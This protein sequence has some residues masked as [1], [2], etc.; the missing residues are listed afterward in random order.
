MVC[1]AVD[2][3]QFNIA[4]GHKYRYCD[5]MTGKYAPTRTTFMFLMM[6]VAMSFWGGSWVSAKLISLSMAPEMTAFWRFFLQA[7]V[8]LAVMII[9]RKQ[10]SIGKEKLLLLIGTSLILSCYN[11][12]F[13]FGLQSGFAGK[14]GVIVTCLNPL[15]AFG[16]S[17]IAF[18][19]RIHTMQI[20][21]LSVGLLGGMLLLETSRII[22]SG[23]IDS[24]GFIFVVAALL[25]AGLT[26]MSRKLQKDM[27]LIEFSF[28]LYGMASIELGLFAFFRGNLVLPFSGFA[29]AA[30]YTRDFWLNALYLGLPAGVFAN[31]MY[32]AS[33]RELGADRAASFTFMVPATAVLFSF[34]ILGEQPILSTIIGG[35]LALAA[36]YMVNFSRQ[37]KKAIPRS[38]T[39]SN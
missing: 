37:L 16:I 2:S 33:V 12:L 39:R 36:V 10:F 29:G 20:L 19:T 11:I 28:Y 18:K 13:F 27:G 6:L 30:A 1:N 35:L 8:F 24:T 32:F 23:A 25:W 15:F 22:S 5:P 31:S 7:I 9:C 3:R 34:F 14:S 38:I 26:N 21:G 17:S 4:Q